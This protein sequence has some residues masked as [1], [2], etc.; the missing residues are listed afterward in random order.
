M[1][2]SPPAETPNSESLSVLIVDDD[3]EIRTLLE[4]L[5][6]LEGLNVVGSA[7]DGSVAVSMALELQPDVVV[8][9]YMMPKIDGAECAKFLQA[10]SPYSKII[11]FSG[12]V[13]AK[14]DW[15]DDFISKGGVDGLAEMARYVAL[16]EYLAKPQQES[17][18]T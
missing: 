7:C 12:V 2:G 18:T 15:A 4:T 11:A 5:L 17:V 9:D 16:Q 14:P 6:E 3:P 13:H 10:V 8:L 1:Q